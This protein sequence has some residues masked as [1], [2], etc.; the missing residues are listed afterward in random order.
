MP[1]G[2]AAG[3]RVLLTCRSGVLARFIRAQPGLDGV[4]TVP[5]H[6]VAELPPENFDLV[7]VDEAQD[8]INGADLRLLIRS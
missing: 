4:V 6:Q 8:I 1:A 5:F 3:L 2:R 7:V